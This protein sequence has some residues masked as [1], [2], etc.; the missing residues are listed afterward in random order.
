MQMA[1]FHFRLSCIERKCGIYEQ[2]NYMNY[3]LRPIDTRWSNNLM[4]LFEKEHL[5]RRDVL[6]L[7][8]INISR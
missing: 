4:Y 7:A 2:H 5:C 3:A 8:L 1:P 6:R